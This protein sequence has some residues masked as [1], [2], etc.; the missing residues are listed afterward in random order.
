MLRPGGS[1]GSG[2][3]LQLRVVAIRLLLAGGPLCNELLK[4]F[5]LHLEK[6]LFAQQPFDAACSLVELGHG[7]AV[8][9][10]VEQISRLHKLAVTESHLGE[11]ARHPAADVDHTFGVDAAGD[12][13][14][15]RQS[16]SSRRRDHHLRRHN[17]G[18]LG[19]L[20]GLRRL[21]FLASACQQSDSHHGCSGSE[22]SGGQ[23]GS[24]AG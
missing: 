13:Q 2:I 5:H 22:R 23:S 17:A 12:F 16:G 11:V 15:F 19:R 9:D 21:R 6:P 4:A 18:G 20:F 14:V 1:Q 10:L 3:L 8:V 24:Q 7:R